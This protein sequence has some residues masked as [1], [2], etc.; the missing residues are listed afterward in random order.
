[1]RDSVR[2]LSIFVSPPRLHAALGQLHPRPHELPPEC[3]PDRGNAIQEHP[4]PSMTI[5]VVKKPQLVG[6]LGAFW[7]TRC[8][9]TTLSG[10]ASGIPRFI[11]GFVQNPL[12]INH[13]QISQNPLCTP[14]LYQ[15]S[16]S[17]ASL[18]PPLAVLVPST[19]RADPACNKGQKRMPWS[20][21]SGKKAPEGAFNEC[22]AYGA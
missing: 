13:L 15:K 7:V 17:G 21:R 18:W 3:S 14:S 8:R 6:P 22:Y 20:Q 9:I 4:S 16:A 2:M 5:H 19:L 10:G 11:W 1:M 12:Q